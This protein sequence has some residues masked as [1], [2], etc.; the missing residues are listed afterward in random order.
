MNKR[1]K[2]LEVYYYPD[3]AY[4]SY[5]MR[6]LSDFIISNEVGKLNKMSYAVFF[7]GEMALNEAGS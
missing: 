5:N 7:R 4:N 1:S 6:S 3:I 2:A